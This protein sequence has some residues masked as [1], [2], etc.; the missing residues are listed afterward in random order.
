MATYR[1]PDAV[2]A[3]V[4]CALRQSIPPTEIVIVDASPDWQTQR[5]RFLREFDGLLNGRLEYRQATVAS[6]SAQRN[7]ALELS[8][9][10]IVFLFDDDMYMHEGC[11]EQILRV[12]RADVDQCVMA[13]CGK[14][15]HCNPLQPVHESKDES[16]QA[17]A[18]MKPKQQRSALRAWLMAN[19]RR[20]LKATDTFVPYDDH[21]PT[22]QLPEALRGLKVGQLPLMA[23]GCMT[24]R[25]QPAL[26]TRFED[27]MRRYS[28][29][30]D[31]D[32][33][34][35]LSRQGLLLR[36]YKAEGYHDSAPGGKLGPFTVAT[37]GAINPLFM[38]RLYS[39]DRERSV[40][41]SRRMLARRIAIEAIEDMRSKDFTFPR[42]RGYAFGLCQVR[43]ILHVADE[44]FDALY[45]Y[46][47]NRAIDGK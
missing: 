14:Q 19:L 7:Q 12:Y 44:Q 17:V 43:R 13:V 31:S 9:S 41:R 4:R 2:A 32:F 34:Y 6:S 23:G 3:A 18:A 22:W 8:R 25:R 40:R 27:R 42:A 37:L 1:R 21:F 35:R 45:E 38:H 16:A 36:A 33:S 29:G 30:E 5:D 46:L 11:A 47:Q 24:V 20:L 39:S 15:T 10:D 28:A 26:E